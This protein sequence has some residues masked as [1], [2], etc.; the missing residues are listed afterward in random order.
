MLRYVPIVAGVVMIVWLGI[1]QGLKSDRW[2]DPAVGAAEFAARL[3]EVPMEVGSWRG[4][5]HSAEADERALGV[6]GAV[7]HRSLTYQNSIDPSQVVSVYL[8]CGH[9]RSITAHTPDR[10]YPASGFERLEKL[11]KQSLSY[12]GSM[13]AD[14][15]TT[16]FSKDSA[17]GRERLRVF[18]TWA[19]DDH[20][21][22]PD[23]PTRTFA[24]QRA[25]YKMYL[26]TPLVDRTESANDSVCME[27]ARQFLP[28]LNRQLFQAQP[29]EPAKQPAASG[30]TTALRG[31]DCGGLK[32]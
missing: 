22:A 3:S 30:Q 2:T 15:Y 6:A 31:G 13:P 28:K 5:D 24:A 16:V 23:S 1:V 4:T 20:W 11:S 12:G 14:F 25:L 10:C 21:Q 29:V 8:V 27:F 32:S 18:W 26:I 19:I 17:E 9:S 7:G